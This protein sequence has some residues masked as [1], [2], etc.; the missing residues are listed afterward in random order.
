MSN[1]KG[2]YYFKQVIVGYD[3]NWPEDT[4]LMVVWCE[5]N[6]VGRWSYGLHHEGIDGSISVYA[7]YFEE[8]IDYVSFSLVWGLT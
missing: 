2:Q 4:D 7:F 6:A 5:D 1:H 3:S 8:N